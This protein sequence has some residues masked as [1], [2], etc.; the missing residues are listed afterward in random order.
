MT[1]RSGAASGSPN[2]SYS[3]SIPLARTLAITTPSYR[4]PVPLPGVSRT[5][6]KRADVEKRF[7]W[8]AESVFPDEAGWEAAAETILA[9][10]PD[11]AEFKGHLGESPEMLA[12]WFDAAESAQ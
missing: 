6:P 12:D 8:D 9:K 3:I 4:R 10:L 5:L 11:L 1:S 7:T 2:A